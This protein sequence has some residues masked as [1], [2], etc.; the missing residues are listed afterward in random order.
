MDK[1]FD[2]DF[3]KPGS[4]DGVEVNEMSIDAKIKELTDQIASANRAIALA[5]KLN[6]A[7]YK[8]KAELKKK[9]FEETLAMLSLDKVVTPPAPTKPT[10]EVADMDDSVYGERRSLTNKMEKWRDAHPGQK[11]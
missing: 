7:E 11:L 6:D 8:A 9:G 5:G 4:L 3:T 1:N 10:F 2:L